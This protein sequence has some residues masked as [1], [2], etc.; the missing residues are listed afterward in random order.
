MIREQKKFEFKEAVLDVRRVTRVV[1]GGKR[2][3]FRAT[4]VVGNEKGKVGVGVSK[5]L[6]VAQAIAKARNQA[7]KN[8]FTVPLKENTIPYDVEAKFSAARVLIRPAKSGRGLKAG[9]S[10]RAVLSLAGIKDASA[11]CLGGTKNKLTNALATTEAL[12][13]LKLNATSST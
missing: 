7:T 6:D 13:K 11:K 9:G 5:G 8:L 4:V 1:A 3:R 12:K 2:F 10:V